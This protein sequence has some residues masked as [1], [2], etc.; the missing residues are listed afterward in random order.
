MRTIQTDEG[1]AVVTNFGNIPVIITEKARIYI[2]W[3]GIEELLKYLKLAVA[4]ARDPTLATMIQEALTKNMRE[5][6]T[7]LGTVPALRLEALAQIEQLLDKYRRRTNL[8]TQQLIILHAI[9]E[10]LQR[11]RT[12]IQ[13]LEMPALLY[14]ARQQAKRNLIKMQEEILRSL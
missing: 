4:Y 2:P 11:Y 1:L 7:E 14:L 6:R 9:M 13:Q 12:G 8:D 3:Q 5:L 10:L